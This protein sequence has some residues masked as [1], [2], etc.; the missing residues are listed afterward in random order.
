VNDD[1]LEKTINLINHIAR[2]GPEGE[3]GDGK[4][5]ILPLD[6]VWQVGGKERGQE[7]I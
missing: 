1:F 6:D 5:F 3:I 7:A 2:T 4:V